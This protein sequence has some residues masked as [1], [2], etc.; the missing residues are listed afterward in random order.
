MKNVTQYLIE[1][2]LTAIILLKKFK[3][4]K[5]IDLYISDI[6]IFISIF[7][8]HINQIKQIYYTSKIKK[9]ATQKHSLNFS[10]I[11]ATNSNFFQSINR[12]QINQLKIIMYKST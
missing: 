5:G 1:I 6:E 7:K 3:T 12:R 4:N 8:S 10:I 11:H 9:E 2:I